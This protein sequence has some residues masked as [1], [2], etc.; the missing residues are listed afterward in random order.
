MMAS[1]YKAYLG[2]GLGPLEWIKQYQI[3]HPGRVI[4]RVILHLTMPGVLDWVL[5]GNNA[6]LERARPSS[7]R[8]ED[9]LKVCCSGIATG[10]C[11]IVQLSIF[12]LVADGSAK[13][14]GCLWL[15]V[16]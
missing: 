7:C 14:I 1:T 10:S 9:R 8:I 6:H 4:G 2:E 16:L 13:Q 12:V 15:V 5:G 3:P 11:H